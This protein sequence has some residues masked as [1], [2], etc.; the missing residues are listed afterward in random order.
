MPE[1]RRYNLA[2]LPEDAA[3]SARCIELSQTHF[4]K[5]A[6]NYLLGPDSLPHV[7]LCQFLMPENHVKAVWQYVEATLGRRYTVKFSNIYFSP[8][9]AEHRGLMTTGLKA[10]PEESYTS[11]QAHLHGW[12][13]SRGY[14]VRTGTGEDYFP[15]LT[16][17]VMKEAPTYPYI[18]WPDKVLGDQSRAFSLSLG[19]SNEYGA[20]IKRL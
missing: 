18:E 5:L 14:D 19:L 6:I 4:S 17:A 11:I 16:L 7:T 15:H 1:I 20:Y 3:F 10:V 8:G 9:K 12:L 2:L 13:D